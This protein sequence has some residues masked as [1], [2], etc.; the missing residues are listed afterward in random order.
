VNT[1][2]ILFVDDEPMVLQGLQRMLRQMR[3]E[4]DMV[5]A[6]GGEAALKLM[7]QAPFDV[8]VTDMRMPGMNGAELLQQVMRLYP[9]TVRLVLS[10]HADRDLVAQCVGVAHQYISKPCEPEQLKTTI[11]SV[12]IPGGDQAS[13]EIKRIAGSII[14]LPSVPLLYSRLRRALEDENA[15]TQ[16]LGDI[17]QTDIGMTAKILKL[18][19]SAFFGLRRTIDTPHE[20]VAYLG[21]ETVKTL[22]LANGIFCESPAL[23]TKIFSLESLWHHSLKVANGARAIA[24]AEEADRHIQ[25]ASFVG[26]ILH[27][28]GILLLAA[29]FP[30]AYDRVVE[31]VVQEHI[32]VPQAEERLF[33]IS[34]A[35]V[36]AYLLGL[37]GIPGPILDIVRKHHWPLPALP[38]GFSPILAVHTA[39]AL[40]GLK[41]QHPLFEGGELDEVALENAGLKDRIAVWRTLLSNTTGA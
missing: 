12:C 4:W 35:E 26:G 3:G 37:W 2:R 23:E 40:S 21:V 41:N 6:T 8:I 32:P 5:F 38:K 1:K 15:T 9:S 20:A 11:R 24:M 33:R 16:T 28:V 25:E 29:N 22:V 27:D 14:H 10:G 19:N 13:E 30:E 34:H 31:I 17:I 7:A 18:V 36:G 39:D